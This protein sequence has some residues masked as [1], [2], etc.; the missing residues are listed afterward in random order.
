[1]NITIEEKNE[2]LS[3][4]CEA[5]DRREQKQEADKMVFRRVCSK[6]SEELRSFD[7]AKPHE[8]RGVDGKNHSY[9]KDI[10]CHYRIETAIR[11]LVRIALQVDTVAKMPSEKEAEILEFADSVLKLKRTAHVKFDDKDGLISDWLAVLDCHPHIHDYDD[12]EQRTEDA[13]PDG[14]GI[15]KFKKHHHPL[16]V[17]PW[18]PNVGDKVI[19]LFLPVGNGHGFVLG[20]YQPWQ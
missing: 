16:I 19:T 14:E 13:G 8:Y 11:S 6:L 17:K 2:L 15:E 18:L 7:Y 3:L 20:A 4:V 10:S 5:M 12:E 1:M 9:M